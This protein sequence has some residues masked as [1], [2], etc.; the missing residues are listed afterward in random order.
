MPLRCTRHL[1]FSPR[2]YVYQVCR[3]PFCFRRPPSNEETDADKSRSAGEGFVLPGDVNW[4]LNGDRPPSIVGVPC[5]GAIVVGE[6]AQLR[7]GQL[8]ARWHV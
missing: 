6:R 3:F 8:C 4:G 1:F 7:V 5:L 2:I